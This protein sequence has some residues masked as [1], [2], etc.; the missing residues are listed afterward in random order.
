[1]VSIIIPTYKRSDTLGRAIDSC[2]NQTVP[3]IEII[4]VDDN[5]PDTEYRK[6]TEQ[7]MQR[8]EDN[9]RVRY[10]KHPRNLKGSAAR[11]TGIREAKGDYITFLDDDDVLENTKI[12]KQVQAL[13]ACDDTYGVVCCGVKICDADTGKQMRIT[14]PNKN[15]NVQFEMLKL[16]LGMGTGSNPLFSREAVEKTGFFDTSF[17][18]HQD[19]EYLI[20]IL[21][22]YKLITIPDVLIT[23]YESG[24][25][26]RPSAEKYMEIQEHFLDTFKTDIEKY[27]QEQQNEIYRNNWHQMCIIAVDVRNWKLACQC[28]KKA[29]SYM[30]YT[31]RMRLGIIRHMLNGRY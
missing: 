22:N 20:R 30:K 18:R 13:S 2:L 26:N 10:L 11:N 15:G 14:V 8:Y 3:D 28:Y 31:M 6:I 23:K 5:D 29:K 9:P 21:R 19:L 16:R 7:L 27:T 25:P 12:E 24:H 17:L 1:M 4:V